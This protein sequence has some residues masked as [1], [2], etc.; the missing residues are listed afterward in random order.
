MMMANACRTALLVF[1]WS[2][3]AAIRIEEIMYHPAPATAAE[4][5]QGFD[6]SSFEYIKLAVADS[7]APVEL[8]A[9]SLTAGVTF[10]FGDQPSLASAVLRGGGSVTVAKNEDAFVARYGRASKVFDSYGANFACCFS[11]KLANNGETVLLSTGTPPILTTVDE[12]SYTAD[13][14]RIA[15]DGGGASLARG[16]DG[17]MLTAYDAVPSPLCRFSEAWTAFS[18]QGGS[19][20]APV[21]VFNEVHYN[22]P[23]RKISEWRDDPSRVQ[24]C[25]SDFVWK[26]AGDLDEFV[27]LYNPSS[28]QDVDLASWQLSGEVQFAFPSDG[29]ASIAPHG[30]LLLCRAFDVASSIDPHACCSDFQDQCHFRYHGKLSNSGGQLTLTDS[31]GAIVETMRYGV[32]DPWPL[33]ANGYGSSLERLASTSD[34]T[35]PSAWTSSRLPEPPPPA[36]PAPPPRWG[37]PPPAPTPFVAASTAGQSNSIGSGSGSMGIVATSSPVVTPA[38]L[39]RPVGAASFQIHLGGPEMSEISRV[40]LLWEA[41]GTTSQAPSAARVVLMEESGNIPGLYTATVRDI[42]QGCPQEASG[43]IVRY[44]ARVHGSSNRF[45]QLPD[46]AG[47]KPCWS[48]FV[49]SESG[50]PPAAGGTKMWLFG[51]PSPHTSGILPEQATTAALTGVAIWTPGTESVELFDGAK[52]EVT[53]KGNVEITFVRTQRWQGRDQLKVSYLSTTQGGPTSGL[54][55]DFGFWLVGAQPSAAWGPA[56]GR[57]QGL[58]TGLAG[59]WNVEIAGAGEHAFVISPPDHARFQEAGRGDGGDIWKRGFFSGYYTQK[60]NNYEERVTGLSAALDQ[61]YQRPTFGSAEDTIGDLVDV[62]SFIAYLLGNLLTENWDGYINNYF[63]HQDVSGDGRLDIVPWDFDQTSSGS[64]RG[65]DTDMPPSMG[66]D[67]QWYIPAAGRRLQRGPDDPNTESGRECFDHTDNDDDGKSDCDDPDCTRMCQMGFGRGNGRSSRPKQPDD[68]GSFMSALS[69]QCGFAQAFVDAYG[70][71]VTWLAGSEVASYLSSREQE[72]LAQVA[73]ME[74]EYG[75]DRSQRRSEVSSAYSA[76][77]QYVRDRAAFMLANPML[78]PQWCTTSDPGVQ[79]SLGDTVASFT[80]VSAANGVWQPDNQRVTTDCRRP[81]GP[82]T[83]SAC[84]CRDSYPAGRQRQPTSPTSSTSYNHARACPASPP[85]GTHTPAAPSPPTSFACTAAELSALTANNCPRPDA[86]RL[87]PT[88]CPPLCAQAMTPWWQQVSLLLPF[89][90]HIEFHLTQLTTVCSV[91]ACTPA[92][93]PARLSVQLSACPPVCDSVA[94]GNFQCGHSQV[95]SDLD[96]ALNH[97]LGK[98]ET[99][100]E[101]MQGH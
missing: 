101:Q 99:L 47:P 15:S 59:M 78:L 73:A 62:S 93:P 35:L 53:R 63:L 36:P 22:P 32:E 44:A 21:V 38:Q 10:L 6:D 20:P 33:A 66:I 76:I 25:R 58:V 51:H 92:R 75:V 55:E 70:P 83:A 16:V 97:D 46:P 24:E 13:A 56:H 19:S 85:W 43:C 48:I 94:S 68:I 90:N 31:H 39:Q 72:L 2:C 52:V 5:G 74:A 9:I 77:A 81:A 64:T 45:R 14:Y 3:V 50:L 57:A 80:T 49:G 17:T 18:R 86:G 89:P 11:G 28:I 100:C 7:D 29:S 65:S 95:A 8:G 87:V 42:N 96:A 84:T 26:R 34:P 69:S 60:T 23:N 91:Y 71:T 27:E 4:H 1:L 41:V 67:G 61:L 98:F 37:A 79:R 30:T 40:E 88:T 54:L 82:A 12:F